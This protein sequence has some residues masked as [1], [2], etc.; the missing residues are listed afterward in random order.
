MRFGGASDSKKGK[1]SG[2]TSKQKKIRF[3]VA[4]YSKKEKIPDES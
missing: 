1:G 3:G 2:G 4:S